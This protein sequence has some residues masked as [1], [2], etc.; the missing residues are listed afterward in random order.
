MIFEGQLLS[1][2]EGVNAP[3]YGGGKYTRLEFS[4]VEGEVFAL[5]AD[6]HLAES[7]KGAVRKDLPWTLGVLP[8]MQSGKFAMRIVAVSVGKAKV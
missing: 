4:P 3:E 5:R 7:L 8:R 1:M 6:G 2:Q